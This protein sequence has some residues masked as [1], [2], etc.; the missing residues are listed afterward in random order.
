MY[1]E[2]SLIYEAMVAASELGLSS[3]MVDLPDNKPHGFW[4]DRHGNFIRVGTMNHNSVARNILERMKESFT[5]G[6][7][8]DQ[9]YKKGWVRIFLGNNILLW[10]NPMGGI[11]NIQK[12]NMEFIADFYNL[13]NGVTEDV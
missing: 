9:L 11:N 2:L 5:L 3:S 10:E 4:M 8:Y 12:R 13:S 6:T 1:E 7:A